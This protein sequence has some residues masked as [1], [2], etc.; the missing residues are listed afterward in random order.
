MKFISLPTILAAALGALAPM[1]PAAAQDGIEQFDPDTGMDAEASGED[2]DAAAMAMIGAMVSSMFQ[3]DPLAA[4]AE[5]RLPA[6]SAVAASLVPEGVYGEMMSQMMD[7]FL[8]PIFDLADMGAGMSTLDLVEYTGLPIENVEVLTAEQRIELTEIFD[9]VHEVRARAEIEAITT[10][11][12]AIFTM[13]E[14]GMRE[15]LA[16]AYATRFNASELAAMQAF[17]ATPVGA[18][19][20]SQSLVMNTDPQVIAGMMQSIPSLMEQLPTLLEGFENAEAGLPEPR[21]FDDLTPSEKRRAAELLGIDQ[22]DLRESMANADGLAAEAVAE[23]AEDAEAAIEGEDMES[24]E[25]AMDDLGQDTTG[26]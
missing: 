5:A 26:Q 25:E 6:A 10:G 16:K 8:A 7:S 19:Y 22:A 11:A 14:P 24:F 15:G 20:A 2:A 9:P 12:N 21:G 1:Q 4:D 23:A 3:A 13:L 17:F 18:K